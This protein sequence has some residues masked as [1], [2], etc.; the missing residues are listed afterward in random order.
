MPGHGL[1]VLE[2]LLLCD[3][4]WE[5]KQASYQVLRGGDCFL[6][7]PHWEGKLALC[8]VLRQGDCGISLLTSP[9]GSRT[10]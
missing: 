3:P 4:C 2:L 10:G 7:D 8:Q 9:R 1:Q 6:C 5:G